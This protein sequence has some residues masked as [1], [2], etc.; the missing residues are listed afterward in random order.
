MSAK[1]KLVKVEMF[2][3]KFSRDV[4]ELWRLLTARS[5]ED[6]MEIISDIHHFAH[7]IDWMGISKPAADKF[8]E[9]YCTPAAV[10]ARRVAIGG[11]ARANHNTAISIIQSA[12]DCAA[13]SAKVS[14]AKK[15]DF[16]IEVQTCE[17]IGLGAQLAEIVKSGDYKKL[18]QMA[19]VLK[20]GPP[21]LSIKSRGGEDAE[22]GIV[23]REFCR[24]HIE[25][26]GLPTKKQLRDACG[27]GHD[28]EEVERMRK[29]LKDL[30]LSE[31]P[32]ANRTPAEK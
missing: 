28:S 16:I 6:Q 25:M 7:H 9:V 14:S 10:K 26:R 11:T 22:I 5:F 12:S 21:L 32:K 20:N 19:A 8:I 13:R 27:F 18:E 23:F 4:D 29:I 2:G 15:S 17:L 3:V 24:L 30:G 1:K 31:I